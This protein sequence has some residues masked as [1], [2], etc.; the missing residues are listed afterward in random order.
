MAIIPSP[1]PGIEIPQP[2]PDVVPIPP[3]PQPP[4]PQ[5]LPP[6][7]IDPP[8][9]PPAPVQEPGPAAPPEVSSE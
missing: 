6:D 4:G 5:E 1:N 3:I 2:G 9:A 7:V 8:L